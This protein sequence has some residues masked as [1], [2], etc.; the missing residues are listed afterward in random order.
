ML[1]FFFGLVRRYLRTRPWSL[2]T[3]IPTPADPWASIRQGCR[4]VHLAAHKCTLLVAS[5]D[6]AQR[7]RPTSSGPPGQPPWNLNLGLAPDARLSGYVEHAPARHSPSFPDWSGAS[8]LGDLTG[9]Q[10]RRD[11]PTRA[12]CTCESGSRDTRRR[13]GRRNDGLGRWENGAEW[14][15]SS[16]SSPPLAKWLRGDLKVDVYPA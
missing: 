9:A 11:Q 2:L 5:V 8:A 13:R 6:A 15:C 10:Q 3:L 16:S 12:G 1:F 4:Q 7:S 14:K